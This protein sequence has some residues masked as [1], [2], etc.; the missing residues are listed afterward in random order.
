MYA[1]LGNIRF[2]GLKGFST[3]SKTVAVAYAQHARINGKARLEAT[4]DELDAISFDM[5]LHANFTDPEADIDQIE[6]ACTD[7]EVLKLILGN[8]NIVGDFVITSIEDVI[9]FTDPKGNIISATLSISLLESYNENPL[10]EAQKNAANS[11]FATTARN[12][13]VRS[14][15]PAKPSPAAGVVVNVSKINA[16]AVQINQYAAAAEANTNTFAYY[17]D[18]V[19]SNLNDI[20]DY[21]SDAQAQLSDAQDLYN[22]ATSLPAALE[23]VNTRVQNIKAVLPISDISQFKILNSQLQGSVLAART[24]NVG[25]SNQSIIRRK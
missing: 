15:L 2:E 13:N 6:T 21:I 17:S 22:L 7:R 3:F 1:Q 9:E 24:A 16:S 11:A 5:L 10:G 4:G 19:D 14:V 8:G 25:I 12:S 18:K 23:D 20:E